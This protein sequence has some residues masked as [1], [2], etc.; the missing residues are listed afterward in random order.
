[1]LRQIVN[2]MGE[3][4]EQTVEVTVLIPLLP[5]CGHGVFGDS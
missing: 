4:V 3:S 1:M 2:G 5:V